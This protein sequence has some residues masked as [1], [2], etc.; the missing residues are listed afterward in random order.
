[1]GGGEIH[2]QLMAGR[3]QAAPRERRTGPETPSAPDGDTLAGLRRAAA[4]RPDQAGPLRDLGIALAA[5]GRGGEAIAWLRR[6]VALD[7]RDAVAHRHLGAA[8]AAGGSLDEAAACLERALAL[9]PRDRECRS[10]A[11]QLRQEMARREAALAPL[12]AKL[13]PSPEDPAALFDLGFALGKQGRLAEAAACYR[14]VLALNDA[15]LAALNNLGNALKALGELDEAAGC[16]RRA[17]ALRPDLPALRFNLGNN[18]RALGRGDEAVEC[19]RAAVALK[20]DYDEARYALAMALL[21]QGDLAAGFAEYEWRWQRPEPV[22]A[23]AALAQPQWRGEAA[24]TD[25]AEGGPERTLLI[26]VEGGF[27][28]TLHFCRYA[29]LAAARGWRVVLEAQ[30]PLTRLLRGLEGADLV[31]PAGT[32]PPPFARHCPMLSLPAALGTTLDSVPAPRSPPFAYLRADPDAA[33]AMAARLAAMGEARTRAGLPAGPR[34]GVVWAGDPGAGVPAKAAIDQRRSV[35]PDRLAPLFDVAGVWFF[36]LRKGGPAAPA[37]FGLTDLMDEMG[38][39]ADT[40]ALVANLDLVIAVDTAVAHLAAAM[41]RPVWVLDRTD[42]CWRW[43]DGRSDT[44]WYPTLRLIRQ[45][46]PGDWDGVA[47][48]AAADLAAWVGR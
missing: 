31:L 47:A 9:A 38:D 48:A 33:A 45:T 16:Y 20:P 22:R 44:P 39:F 40:A 21:G 5:A 8:L 35:A 1:M 10:L 11:T 42:H 6:A 4:R 37:A 24:D 46:S 43:L 23:R 25:A 15:N 27:G 3:G 7:G 36:S 18:L 14:R 28:D 26:H 13:A 41:G 19:Y 32:A 29:K 34:V 12:R 30:A 2:A 17:I